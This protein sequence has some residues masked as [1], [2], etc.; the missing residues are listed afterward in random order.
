MT[1]SK[2]LNEKNEREVFFDKDRARKYHLYDMLWNI[3]WGIGILY[4]LDFVISLFIDVFSNYFGFGI[5]LYGIVVGWNVFGYFR[6]IYIVGN[7]RYWLSKDRLIRK[8]KFLT[9]AT[10]TARLQVVNSIDMDQSIVMRFLGI[11]KVTIDYGF[12][13]EGYSFTFKYLDENEAN[14]VLDEIKV[15]ALGVE[16]K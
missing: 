10:D 14:K 2:K 15:R 9:K 12:G 1:S 7:L 4:G 5:Y 8:Y 3:G 11:F 6:S 13:S 16:V